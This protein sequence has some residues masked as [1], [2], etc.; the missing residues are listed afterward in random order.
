MNEIWKCELCGQS[1]KVVADKFVE[2]PQGYFETA[3]SEN[4]WLEMSVSRFVMQMRQNG[5]LRKRQLPT[6]ESWV[7]KDEVIQSYVRWKG[8]Q[9]SKSFQ[10]KSMPL[11]NIAVC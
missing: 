5:F 9:F 10:T 6:F 2:L 8:S 11:K 7:R 4:I 1:V 3:N